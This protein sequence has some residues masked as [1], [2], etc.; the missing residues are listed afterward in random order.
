V[1]EPVPLDA[2]AARLELGA[3]SMVAFVGGGG[4][5][6]TMFAVG[7]TLARQEA[8]TVV[9]TTT[10]RMAAGRTDGFT[11]LTG[12]AV[13]ELAAAAATEPILAWR[14]VQGSKATGYPPPFCDA[15]RARVDHVLIEADGAR[16]MPLTAPGPLEPVIPATATHVVAMMGAEALGR[17][18]GD[19]CHRPLRVAALA[20]CRP[21][22]RLTA[23]GAARVLLSDRGLRKGVPLSARFVVAISKVVHPVDRELAEL[24][25]R[26]DGTPLI[27]ILA[28]EGRT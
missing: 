13:E 24:I 20:G 25:E 27:P 23:E 21:F 9:M 12:A 3:R 26:L 15:L 5:T 17:C 1:I 7:A 8:G 11:T 18:I 14:S 2:V 10:T 19:Q 16:R 22:D 28:E 4:K 6:T